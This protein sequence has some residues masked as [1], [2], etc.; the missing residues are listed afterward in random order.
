M[1]IALD[2]R[3]VR[4]QSMHGIA[5]YVLELLSCLK[6]T[7]TTDEIYVLHSRNSPL[8]SMEWPPN[9]HFVPMLSNWISLFEQWELPR[10]LKKLQI[11]LFHAPSFV[12]PLICPCKL[13]M[14]IHDLNH[15]GL[16]QF[17]T[18]IHQFYYKTLVR[19][20]VSKSEFV[21]TISQ[22]SKDQ[23]VHFLKL[24][25]EK[26]WV[27][28]CGVSQDF[29]P[30]TDKTYLSYIKSLYQLPDEFILCVSNNKPHK[31]VHQLVRAYC[32]SNIEI[33]LVL[34]CP[35]EP[36]MIEI[37][38]NYGKKHLIYF[39]KYVSDNHLP[40]IYNL[41]SLFVYPS[42]YEGFG[43]PPLEAMACGTPVVVA[44]S[45]SLPEVVGDAAIFTDPY[46]YQD[47]ASALEKG[48]SNPSLRKQL[49]QRGLERSKIFAWKKMSDQT[50][51]AYHQCFKLHSDKLE[52][53]RV[54]NI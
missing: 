45:S 41:A 53:E 9:F 37:A 24:K 36:Q 20:C 12:A 2:A 29:I 26:I 18:L 31:N 14:T 10:V 8:L 27:T 32:F 11:E 28:Y 34:A 44:N 19:Y 16:P 13:I 4:S 21:M 33:P 54:Q 52:N 42:T 23:I 49:K 51:Q 25:P 38:E 7:A 1:R 39:V 15:L 3:M 48:L 17:Y 40:A 35:V 5:R 43:L 47:I 6:D 46:N 30:I 50:L 22:F